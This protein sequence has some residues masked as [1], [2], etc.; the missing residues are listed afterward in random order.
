MSSRGLVS[1]IAAAVVATGSAACT[2][3][4]ASPSDRA[5]CDQLQQMLDALGGQRSLDAVGA[6]DAMV[7]T[8]TRAERASE[9]IE[10]ARRMGEITDARVDESEL[11]MSEV[12]DLARDAMV[13]SGDALGGLVRACAEA[14]RPVTGLEDAGRPS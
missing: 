6:Y 12:S 3:E 11:P 8:A 2:T 4:A 14:G 10:L 9:V 1:I 13:R 7:A 5:V